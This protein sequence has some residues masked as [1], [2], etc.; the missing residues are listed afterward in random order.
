[1]ILTKEIM[2][3]LVIIGMVFKICKFLKM[4]TKPMMP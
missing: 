4:K 3:L 1:M 2:I